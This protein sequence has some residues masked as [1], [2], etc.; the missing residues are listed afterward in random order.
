MAKYII[1][2]DERLAYEEIRRMMQRLRPDYM[3][4][5]WATGVEQAVL[6]LASGGID[7]MI[8]DIRLSDG[9]SFEIFE[10]T[11]ADIPVIF[12]TAYDEYALRAFKVNSIDYLLKPVEEQALDTF[13]YVETSDIA[14]FYS[15]EKYVFL[16]LFSSRRYIVDYTL[17]QLETMLDEASFFRVSR[18]CIANIRALGKVSRYFGGRLKIFFSPECPHEVIV[19]RDRTE[20]VL[21][22]ID[23]IR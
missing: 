5:G 20:R 7:L 14:F 17:E 19:S 9:L 18:N 21:Q 10:R 16:H 1:I 23:D 2:E 15:E 13:R 4:T 3:L 8:V 6:Q 11:A 22:W 12:T